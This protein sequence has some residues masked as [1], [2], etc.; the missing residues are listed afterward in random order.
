LKKHIVYTYVVRNKMFLK[1]RHCYMCGI[2][3]F[4]YPPTGKH[5]Q[6]NRSLTWCL[7]LPK[8]HISTGVYL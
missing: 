2:I 8:Y 3:G 6:L 7:C 5:K 4:L 1:L